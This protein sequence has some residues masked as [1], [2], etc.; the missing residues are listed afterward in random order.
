M[1]GLLGGW[2]DGWMSS[3]WL[4]GRDD[5]QVDGWIT[6]CVNGRIVEWAGG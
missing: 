2:V 3:R 4:D 5:E 6:G 1:T